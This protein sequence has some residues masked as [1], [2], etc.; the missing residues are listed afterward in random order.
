[1]KAKEVLFVSAVATLTTLCLQAVRN[2]M[3]DRKQ[4][5]IIRTAFGVRP[6]EK[7]E[8]IGGK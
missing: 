3:R 1:M 7:F 8:R 4:K 6:G 5:K 2:E